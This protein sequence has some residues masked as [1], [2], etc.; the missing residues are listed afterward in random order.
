MSTNNKNI[1]VE[2]KKYEESEL[3]RYYL[4]KRAGLV[5]LIKKWSMEVLQKIV[6][7]LNN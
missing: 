7:L 2:W 6:C 5:A 1:S 3:K 4:F